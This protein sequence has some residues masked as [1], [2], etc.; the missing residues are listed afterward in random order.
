MS[1]LRSHK[2][3]ELPRILGKSFTSSRLQF[4]I[5]KWDATSPAYCHSQRLR[6]SYII[7]YVHSHP[8]APG[9]K[10]N[11]ALLLCLCPLGNVHNP[12]RTGAA[13]GV[14]AHRPDHVR[15]HVQPVLHADDGDPFC[16]YWSQTTNG[17]RWRINGMDM[18]VIFCSPLCRI[19]QPL[20]KWHISQMKCESI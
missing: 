1:I 8:A 14:D 5:Y 20:R 10:V 9:N 6:G 4:W 3:P 18:C 16:E 17:N 7:I 12:P 2:T 19:Q 11:K 13:A 15:R